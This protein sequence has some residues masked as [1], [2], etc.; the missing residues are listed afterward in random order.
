[1]FYD[2]A[3]LEAFTPCK[4]GLYESLMTRERSAKKINDL[5]SAEWEALTFGH[6]QGEKIRHQVRSLENRRREFSGRF[7]LL[8][9]FFFN[10]F[11]RS[12]SGVLPASA[13]IIRIA[14]VEHYSRKLGRKVKEANDLFIICFHLTNNI[15]SHNFTANGLEYH[16]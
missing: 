15:T 11:K 13:N 8:Y 2:I 6:K 3:N 7:I 5:L 4:H 16:W 12:I 1:M 14:T 9:L 10:N